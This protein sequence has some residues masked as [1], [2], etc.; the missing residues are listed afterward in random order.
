MARGTVINFAKQTTKSRPSSPVR[1]HLGAG[2]PV[3][4]Y[5]GTEV[6]AGVGYLIGSA[7]S[8]LG[9]GLSDVAR[10]CGCSVQFIS[11]IEHGRAPL[12]PNFVEPIAEKLKLSRDKL[13]FL[14]LQSSFAYKELK[15]FSPRMDAILN[16][17]VT[18][19]GE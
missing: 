12:P 4:R 14:A 9:L 19:F 3:G 17:A 2:A 18:Q 16:L 13:A 10:V 15:R 11:N 8:H 1:D 6:D 7:R 5:D